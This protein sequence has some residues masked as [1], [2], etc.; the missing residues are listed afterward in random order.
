MVGYNRQH[1]FTTTTHLMPMKSIRCG[2][3]T[4]TSPSDLFYTSLFPFSS[5]VPFFYA[6]PLAI[7]FPLHYVS[8]S[9]TCPLPQPV[10]DSC[11]GR[12]WRMQGIMMLG[13]STPR[14][15]GHVKIFS[16]A[17]RLLSLEFYFDLSPFSRFYPS[18]HNYDMVACHAPYAALRHPSTTFSPLLISL[19]LCPL[20]SLICLPFWL[21]LIR[22]VI[23]L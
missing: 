1:V 11:H 12:D 3:M 6:I 23:I 18:V 14:Y 10:H 16:L 8:T 21:R 22:D 13:C 19:Y 2:S 5:S 9:R 20:T 4:M 15:L 7:P 17:I